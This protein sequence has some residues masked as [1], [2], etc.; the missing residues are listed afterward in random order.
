M[1]ALVHL[2]KLEK[3]IDSEEEILVGNVAWAESRDE[4]VYL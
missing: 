1:R 4:T 2:N 3:V